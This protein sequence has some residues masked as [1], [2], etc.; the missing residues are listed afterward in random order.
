[1]RIIL[2]AKR[3]LEIIMVLYINT[4]EDIKTFYKN[5]MDSFI[6]YGAGEVAIQFTTLVQYFYG[7]IDIIKKYVV[8]N[9]QTDNIFFNGKE[10]V[11]FNSSIISE[12]DNIVLALGKKTRIEVLETIS[13]LPCNIY[14]I[15]SKRLN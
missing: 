4:L 9:M 5:G 10:V 2:E 6:V 3:K 7:T 14:V 8:S 11:Q 13:D 1:L 15:D 12:N